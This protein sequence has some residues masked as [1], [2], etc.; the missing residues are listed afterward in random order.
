MKRF[1]LSMLALLLV[2][3]M[4]IPALASCGKKKPSETPT[5]ENNGGGEVK[6]RE[7]VKFTGDFTYNDA[8]STLSA[9]WNPHTYQTQD[10]SYPIDF[11]TGGLYTFIFNDALHPVE[12]KEAYRGYKIVPEMAASDPVDITSTLTAE[13]KTTYGIPADATKGYAYTIDLNKEAKWQNGEAINAAT[14][15]YS[16]KQLL[17]PK[18]Q[19]YRAADYIGSNSF[20]I[21]NGENYFYQGS[22]AYLDNRV[23]NGYTMADLTKGADGVYV[24]PNGNKMYIG[25]DFELDWLGGDTLKY[26][27][28]KYGTGYFDTANWATLIAKVNDKGVIPLTDDNLALFTPVTTGNPAWGETAA[29]LPGYF[30]EGK[31]YADNYSFDNVGLKASGEYQIT[32]ILA[33]ALAGFNLFYNLS[34]NWIVYEPYYEAGKKQVEGTNAWTNSYNSSVESTMSYG[35]YKM[36]AFNID[37]DMT[38][39]RNENW[40]GYTDGKHIYVDP[41]DD[42]IYDMYQT[43][44]IFCQKVAEAKTRKMKF[45]KGELMGYGLQSEDF[46]EYRSSDYCHVTPS[47]TIYFFI[48]NGY[49]EAIDGREANEGFDTTKYDLQTMT[50]TSFRKAVAV[51]YDKEALCTAISPARSGGYG[52]IGN[53]YIYDPDTGASY[54]DTR[55]AK[56]ALCD[57]YSVDPANFGGDLD[58][59]VASI[60]GYDPV[61]AK[62]LYAQAFTEALEKGYITDTDN[63]GKCDQTIEIEYAASEVNDFIK[64][65]LK[66]LNEKL[67]EVLV[68]TPFEGKIVFK[69]SAPLGN[70]WSDN[71]KNGL[72]DV[73]LGGWGGSALDPY[74]LSELYA[75]PAK[76]YDAKW[77]NANSVSFK[78]TVN[79]AGIEAAAPV[80]E[81]LE[82]TLR[83]WSQALNGTAVEIGG[84]SYNFGDGIADVETRLS[85]LA[86]IEAT[87][88]QTYDY[89]P[90]IQD[91][92]MSLLSQQVYYVVEDYNAILGRGGIKYLKYN[93][94]D[95]EWATYVS[96]QGGVLKY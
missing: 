57:F 25:L 10:E 45:L 30:V 24:A 85:I 94:N 93:Y 81:E 80:N 52:L 96:S 46:T 72:S 11:L 54:R 14:Y 91:A 59:A 37:K 75:D 21:A 29:D 63:D 34:G 2:A 69:A 16:M 71:I 41:E 55:Y 51:T 6:E 87:V 67:T 66:Y 76:M 36:T 77:F 22:T 64:K 43:T 40:Y 17:D 44:K 48:F 49:K 15:V 62:E 31:Y 84:K 9:N 38:F 7:H 28:D 89:I 32:L 68:G 73:V 92:G 47:E 5:T 82:M 65:T 58:K 83:Q 56:E 90:M 20:A 12:G 27:V 35:P 18:L 42:K 39:E 26:Y 33:K 61:K 53:M 88:L 60:T 95:T 50:L 4:L 79:T 23:T 3:T 19:N 86:K 78:L 1:W 70:N 13:Q 8:V 74:S